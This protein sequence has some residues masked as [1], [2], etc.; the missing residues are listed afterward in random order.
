MTVNSPYLHTQ[1]L[2]PKLHLGQKSEALSALRFERGLGQLEK[3]SRLNSLNLV[4]KHVWTLLS[5]NV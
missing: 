1:I 3:Q 5:L 2:S 4:E